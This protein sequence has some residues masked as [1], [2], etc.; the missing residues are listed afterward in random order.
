MFQSVLKVIAD[1]G[2]TQLNHLDVAMQNLANVNT[3][4]YKAR[5]FE[6]YL[7]EWGVLRGDTRYDTSQGPVQLTRRPLDF[8][9]QGPGYFP[10]TSPDGQVAYTRDGRFTVNRE[11]FLVTERG[12][13]VGDGIQIPYDHEKFLILPDGTVQVQKKGEPEPKTLG[14]LALAGFRNEEG[15][16]PAANNTL[17]PTDKSGPAFWVAGGTQIKQGMVERSTVDTYSQVDSVMRMNASVIA[18]VRLAQLTSELY[19]QSGN[20]KQ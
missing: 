19:R 12:D 7:S 1:N 11:G 15:L 9:I 8:A 5:R 10:V 14:R 6:S 13:L 17:K 16:E 3:P 20:L 2:A 4:G 18:S